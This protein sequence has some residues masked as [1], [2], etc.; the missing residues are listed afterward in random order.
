MELFKLFHNFIYFKNQIHEEVIFI[1]EWFNLGL[2]MC[3]GLDKKI[4]LTS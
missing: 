4:T 3:T 1:D 2:V